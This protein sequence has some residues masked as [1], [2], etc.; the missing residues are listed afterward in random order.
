MPVTIEQQDL[1]HLVALSGWCGASG[2]YERFQNL[3]AL[4][5]TTQSLTF[6]R[7]NARSTDKL[8]GPAYT[9]SLYDA[10]G[11][12]KATTT[13]V[14]PNTVQ[15]ASFSVNL[16]GLAGWYRAVITCP[17][18]ETSPT[19][20]VWVKG[21]AS[22]T[23][24]P[25]VGGSY[26]AMHGSGG[27]HKWAMVPAR[28][29]PTLV[30]LPAREHVAFSTAVAPS[31]LHREYL[32][33][34]KG[35]VDIHR[36]VKSV[37]GVVHTFN[38]QSYA[39]ASLVSQLPSTSLL[40]GPRGRASLG[41][42]THLQPGRNGKTYF[43]DPWRFGRIDADGK[44]T[45]LIGWRHGGDIPGD[46]R[47]N[48][49][50]LELVGD[51]SAVA[52][53]GTWEMW[54]WAWD[55]RTLATDPAQPPIGGEE[56]H[57]GLGPV[58]FLADTRKNR[59]L[60][61][62][63]NG[64]DRSAPAKVT[65]FVTGVLDP[66]DVVCDAGKVYV[67]ER[68]SHRIVAYDAD[69]AA[70][71][72][73][74]VQGASLSHVDA[75]RFVVRDASLATIRAQACVGPEGLFIQDG[76]LYFGSFAM[77]QIKRVHLTTGVIEVVGEPSFDGNSRF[78]KIAL[79]D[80]T[81]G[82]RG[83]VFCSTW[84]SAHFGM[85]EAILPNGTKWGL[86]NPFA[87][88][89]AISQGRGGYWEAMGYAAAVGVGNGRLIFGTSMEG[90]AQMSLALPTDPMPDYDKYIAGR[91]EWE[92]QG[93]YLTHGFHGFGY[94]GLPQPSS[95]AIDYY[96]TVNGTLQEDPAMIAELQAALAAAQAAANQLQAQI[97]GL[98][99]DKAALQAKIDAA[100][101]ALG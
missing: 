71:V 31:Q 50:A 77:Q 74:V 62:Q 5:A 36:T 100:K 13:A 69:T 20:F 45:T 40:D 43:S 18:G 54:G 48:T 53:K 97:D 89:K 32:V 94:Y 86:S 66:W 78:V 88:D 79:S 82:P 25:V 57:V 81:F 60:R 12:V 29:T 44:L 64:H 33:P 47:P 26:D 3:Q 83:T 70:V 38:Q 46:K 49:S 15:A 76:W 73:V 72:R 7:K 27:P 52:D 21:N 1:A 51:W 75:S 34:M 4:P 30:P 55:E 56:P 11:L 42:V 14:T 85:P 16:A 93:L 96:L 95:P 63:F 24:M 19:W 90:V 6:G 68:G 35:D 59:I 9:L 58:L 92:A 67:S 23:E 41:F 17:A 2:N 22:P 80:G 84:S 65:E 28:F 10:T 8:Y 61:A 101:A 99:A 39:Y 91:N 98:V 87:S 37:D